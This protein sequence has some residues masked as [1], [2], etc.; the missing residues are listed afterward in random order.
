MPPGNVRVRA[1]ANDRKFRDRA[2]GPPQP[3]DRHDKIIGASLCAKGADGPAFEFD[4]LRPQ[5]PLIRTGPRGHGRWRRASGNEAFD[6]IADKPHGTIE[7][8]GAHSIAL[9]DRGDFFSDRTRTFV[10]APGSPDYFSHD[11]S[12]NGNARNA[13]CS[14]P[15]ACSEAIAVSVMSSADK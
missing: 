2:P 12:C 9:S 3:G 6:Y 10:P 13:G 8:F 5:T 4:E 1:R 7:A 15:A 11:A 14:F